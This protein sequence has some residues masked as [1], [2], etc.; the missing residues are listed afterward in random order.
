MSFFDLLNQP[1]ANPFQLRG[2]VCQQLVLPRGDLGREV[3]IGDG[4]VQPAQQLHVVE[5]AAI[6]RRI[7]GSFDLSRPVT[8]APPAAICG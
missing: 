1:V 3:F 7:E 4:A 8:N 5:S 6:R 2:L